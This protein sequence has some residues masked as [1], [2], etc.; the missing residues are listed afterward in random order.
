MTFYYDFEDRRLHAK[1]Y[2]PTR[3]TTIS[4]ELVD[5]RQIREFPSDLIFELK[6]GRKIS[7]TLESKDN[8]RLSELQRIIGKRLQEFVNQM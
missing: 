7:Y 2:W 8:K 6:R 1:V 5:T 4:V 3:G